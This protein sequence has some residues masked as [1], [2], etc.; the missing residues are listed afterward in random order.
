[1]VAA[2][3]LRPSG[4]FSK[5]SLFTMPLTKESKETVMLDGDVGESSGGVGLDGELLGMQ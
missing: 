4:C 1:M 2:A 5:M 3:S